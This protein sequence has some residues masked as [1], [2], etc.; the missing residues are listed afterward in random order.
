M[1]YHNLLFK[2]ADEYCKDY[3]CP[4]SFTYWALLEATSV[5]NEGRSCFYFGNNRIPL[6]LFVILC[7]SPRLK[8]RQA[9]SLTRHILDGMDYNGYLPDNLGMRK[10]FG[11]HFAMLAANSTDWMEDA[12]DNLDSYMPS[13][14]KKE[15]KSKRDINAFFGNDSSSSIT[16]GGDE[17]TTSSVSAHAKA[18]IGDDFVAFAYTN[19][20]DFFS[21]LQALWHC[22]NYKMTTGRGPILLENPYLNIFS[23]MSQVGLMDCFPDSYMGMNCLSHFIIVLEE[24]P[25][26][27]N[28]YPIKPPIQTFLAIQKQLSWVKDCE[29]ELVITADAKLYGASLYQNPKSV[30]EDDSRL[31][32]YSELR[33]THLHRVAANLALYENRTIITK[34]DIEDAH[35][36][37]SLAEAK[38]SDALGEFG[39]TKIAAG[40][41]KCIDLLRRED[42]M[43]KST[44]RAR[45]A[46]FLYN[47]DFELF[48]TD[49]LVQK[50]IL[51]TWNPEQNDYILAYNPNYRQKTK[52]NIIIGKEKPEQMEDNSNE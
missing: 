14:N 44:Y 13:M 19:Q 12:L 15:L 21:Y 49:M 2:H 16:I 10:T 5:I 28:P 17:G 25:K 35:N 23:C 38:L 37:L 30:L 52:T 33:H 9:V 43:K 18:Y 1:Q 41:Q 42:C 39:N 36:L 27:K 31:Q 50:K 8:A 48:L 22:R 45:C 51:E 3:E 32:Q 34:E 20:H 4:S 11:L 47:K 26:A 46:S 6:N 29:E 40:R 7:G 24:E